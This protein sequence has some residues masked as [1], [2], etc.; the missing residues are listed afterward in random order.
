M[1]NV[2]MTKQDIRRSINSQVLMLFFLPLGFAGLH[3]GFA[4]PMIWK[5]LQLF[6]FQNLTLMI[7]VTAGCL[8]VFGVC[9]AMVYKLTANVYFGIVSTAVAGK[10][11]PSV[12]KRPH[13]CQG[14]K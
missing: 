5:M 8:I 3:L 10:T 7:G 11:V 6:C 9:Y 4:F 1:Q 14:P 2:G 13:A 12:N